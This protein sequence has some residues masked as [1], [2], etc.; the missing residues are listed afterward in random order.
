MKRMRD[1][2][3]TALRYAFPDLRVN[4]HPEHRVPNTSSVSFAGAEANHILD[5]LEGVAASA[6]P[7]ATATG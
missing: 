5:Q 2:L 7:P 4:G 6:E 3:E 1:R